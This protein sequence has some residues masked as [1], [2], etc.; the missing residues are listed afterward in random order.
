[1]RR[2]ALPRRAGAIVTAGTL[3]TALLA[4][5]SPP[6]VAAPVPI[7]DYARAAGVAAEL[8]DDRNGGVYYD[9]SGQL[10]IAVT[11][12]A[13][14]DAV[15]AAGG[16]A[17]VVTYSTA[18]LESI[19][20]ALDERIAAVDPIPGTSW[21]ADPSTNKVVVEID[22]TV[23][24]ADLARLQQAIAGYGDAV[25]VERLD[26]VLRSNASM[27]GG[28]GIR[29]NNVSNGRLCTAGFNVQNSAGTKYMLT[30]GHCVVGGKYWWERYYNGEYL[31]KMTTFDYGGKDYAVIQY[32]NSAVSP[33]G[34]V[35]VN[36][37][38]QQITDSRYA[39]DGEPV[40]RVGTSSS[41]LVGAVLDPSITVTTNDGAVL[42]GM[43]KTSLCSI[44]GDSGGPLF[45]GSTALGILQGSVDGSSTCN[46]GVSSDRSY[47]T[48]VQWIL[49]KHSLKVY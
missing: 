44:P 22:S 7:T 5:P 2:A 28:V 37:Q 19:H 36:G 43:I 49:N 27:P 31:G 3:L 40:K 12:R 46:S 30:A 10:V 42:T 41:D 48:P 8:G 45:R 21:G 9:D 24:G 17:E 26:G 39:Y 16:V 29:E 15:T 6:A 14:T 47:Y 23:Q 13:A 34:V 20:T 1:M 18:F 33:Y 38:E 4:I 32:L 25:R 35:I 11:D